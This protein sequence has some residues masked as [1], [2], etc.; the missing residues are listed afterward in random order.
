MS[1]EQTAPRPLRKLRYEFGTPLRA[2]AEVETDEDFAQLE[3]AVP[4]TGFKQ[5]LSLDEAATPGKELALDG[6]HKL[7]VQLLHARGEGSQ[8]PLLVFF[9]GARLQCFVHAGAHRASLRTLHWA[10][11]VWGLA[12]A[13][14]LRA[15][16]RLSGSLVAYTTVLLILMAFARGQRSPWRL[17]VL[18]VALSVA[19]LV[20]V[21]M[22]KP[23]PLPPGLMTASAVGLAFS[24][25]QMWRAD[26]PTFAVHT[27]V[28][29]FCA[30][31]GSLDEAKVRADTRRTLEL[32]ERLNQGTFHPGDRE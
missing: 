1:D 5:R 29:A 16:L 12:A 25:F 20:M 18:A 10:A 27:D 17:G 14:L 31:D 28:A 22:G 30:A 19:G 24:T 9:D 6:G 21:A 32:A 26:G 4:A 8:G 23:G 2:L 3:V 7:H 11:V 13:W 15:D